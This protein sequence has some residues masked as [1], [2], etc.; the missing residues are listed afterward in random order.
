MGKDIEKGKGKKKDQTR[1]ALL[2]IGQTVA[3]PSGACAWRTH[4]HED[5]NA[6]MHDHALLCCVA[7]V[8]VVVPGLGGG[9]TSMTCFPLQVDP[10]P[11]HPARI[12]VRAQRRNVRPKRWHN[13]I[14]F[15]PERRDGCEVMGHRSGRDQQNV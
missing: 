5:W 6:T 14:V 13:E 9:A 12:H 1:A 4:V 11:F 3:R 2:Q 7:G 8:V 15:F 10:R